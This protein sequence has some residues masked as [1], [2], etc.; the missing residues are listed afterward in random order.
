MP[1]QQSH[2]LIV[3]GTIVTVKTQHPMLGYLIAPGTVRYPLNQELTAY[4]VDVMILPEGEYEENVPGHRLK[5][6]VICVSVPIEDIAVTGG[7]MTQMISNDTTADAYGQLIQDEIDQI[8]PDSLPDFIHERVM[9]AVAVKANMIGV[10]ID[11]DY[12]RKLSNLA[13]VMI[14]ISIARL[15]MDPARAASSAIAAI[16]SILDNRR[17]SNDIA[18]ERYDSAKAV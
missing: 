18:E 10:K 7:M 17:V 14:D 3:E 16:A 11:V 12:G 15:N 8:K 2:T 9:T 5:P 4:H 13:K 1:D 6:T